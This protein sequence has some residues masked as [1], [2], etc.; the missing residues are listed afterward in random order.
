MASD[1]IDLKLRVVIVTTRAAL[2]HSDDSPEQRRAILARGRELVAAI[3]ADAD[4]QARE[5]ID[6]AHAELD[7]LEA[8]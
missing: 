6:G 8:D 7:A 3:A 4:G 2:R 1:S 5:A